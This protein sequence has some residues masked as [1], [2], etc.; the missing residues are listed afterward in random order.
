MMLDQNVVTVCHR[1]NPSVEQ[2]YIRLQYILAL[3]ERNRKITEWEW[4]LTEPTK[5]Q[6]V[7]HFCY[8]TSQKLADWFDLLGY[9]ERWC[10]LSIKNENELRQHVNTG[11]IRHRVEWFDDLPVE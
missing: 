8:A 9:Q 3:G 6:L 11:D 4:N 5:D 1:T 10:L 7:R 2:R